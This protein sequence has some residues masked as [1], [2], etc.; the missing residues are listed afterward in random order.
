M[1]ERIYI[2]TVRRTDNQITFNN[3]PEELKKR[4][5]MVVEPGE[6]QLYNYECEYLLVPEKL[7]GTWTQLAETRLMIHKHAGAIKYAVL[8]DDVIIKRRNAKYWTGKSNMEKSKR[9]ATSEEISDMFEIVSKWLD[10]E[11]IGVVGISD[12]GT[13]PADTV[14][15]DTMPVYTYL[16]YDGKMLSKVIDEMDITTL[17][18]AEDLLFLFEALSRGIN[19]RKSNEFMY[20]NRSMVDKNLAESR[21]VWTGMFE[22]KEDRPDNYYQSDEHYKSL[23]Y[24]QKKYPHIIKI[25]KD[26]NG[27]KKNRIAWKKIYKPINYGPSLEEFFDV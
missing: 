7:V 24:I 19:T 15:T 23:K 16:F 14:Y 20:D 10:E 13:P 5:I 18:I 6:R 26:E 25:F 21:E 27:K 1:I 9:F 17:R 4:V 3:L 8:D 2:P 11:S 22:N 12:A